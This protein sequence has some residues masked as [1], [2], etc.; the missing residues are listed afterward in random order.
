MLKM[1][2]S[3]DSI[4]FPS[5]YMLEV[6]DLSSTCNHCIYGSAKIELP[7][8]MVVRFTM[9]VSDVLGGCGVAGG[10]PSAPRSPE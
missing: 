3:V 6:R 10:D 7:F 9:N 5:P 8:L 2:G 1:S 4:T